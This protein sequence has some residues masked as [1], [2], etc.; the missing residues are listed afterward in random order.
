MNRPEYITEKETHEAY[1]AWQAEQRSSLRTKLS[2]L[3]D[4]KN[5]MK[6]LLRRILKE[7]D[8]GCSW[9][10]MKIDTMEELALVCEEGQ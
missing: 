6:D 4:D 8:E 9:G 7:C 2:R 3:E 5:K 10:G 1:A